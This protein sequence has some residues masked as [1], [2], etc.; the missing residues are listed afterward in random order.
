M[1]KAILCTESESTC[2][3]SILYYC[4]HSTLQNCQ[5]FL[6]GNMSNTT[7]YGVI[8]I[9]GFEICR[10]K[11]KDKR[12]YFHAVPP[13]KD[14][15]MISFYADYDCERERYSYPLLSLCVCSD[16][17]AQVGRSSHQITVKTAHQKDMISS[18]DELYTQQTHFT[19]TSLTLISAHL[20][21]LNHKS[22]F[23]IFLLQL[24][25]EN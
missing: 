1:E 4:L 19:M 8:N 24:L 15:K 6:Y 21:F 12:Y 3:G 10:G 18:C 14:S 11:T 17:I 23:I 16:C 22:Q 9:E 5:L 7:A 20:L 25:D 13:S 2:T